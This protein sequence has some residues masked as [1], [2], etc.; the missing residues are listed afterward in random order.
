MAI[1]KWIEGARGWPWW[2]LALLL[3]AALLFV[4]GIGDGWAFRM[5]GAVIKTSLGLAL[6]Y[7]AHLHLVSQGQHIPSH[8]NSAAAQSRRLARAV[9][10]AA[11]ALAVALAV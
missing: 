1:R 10:M 8:D 7:Y 9:I 6:G 5:A 2:V 3:L 4:G 11:C